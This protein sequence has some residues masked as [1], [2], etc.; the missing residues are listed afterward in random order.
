M[1]GKLNP[2]PELERLVQELNERRAG[3]VAD[4]APGTFEVEHDFAAELDEEDLRPLPPLSG[5]TQ[6]AVASGDPLEVLLGEAVRRGASDLL[7][8]PGSPPAVRIDGRLASLPA[9][10]VGAGAVEELLAPHLG[11][12]QRRALRDDGAVDFTLRLDGLSG[13]AGGEAGWRFRVNLH[14]QRGA[15]AA[16]LR[17]LPRRVPTLEELNLPPTLA[18]LVAPTRGLVLVCGPTGAGK[19]S[20]LAALV[21][22]LNRTRAAHVITIEDPIE[23]EHA[24]RQCL[25]EQVEVGTDAPSFAA[26]LRAGLRQDPDVILVGEMRDLETVATAL[27]AAET[28]HLILATLHTNDVVQAVH[29]IVDFFPGDQQSQIRQQL[30]L[31]LHAIVSQQLVP[32]RDRPGRVPAVEVLTATYA[33]RNHIRNQHLHRLYNEVTLGKRHGMVS[34]EDSLARLVRGGVVEVEEARIRSAHPE[35]LE[36][37]LRGGGGAGATT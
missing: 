17:A 3:A 32:R 2:D 24:S 31:A 12:R 37:L 20:T 1:S 4:A 8:V 10:P 16:A 36:S 26:A 30:A 21:G 25:V 7:L 13:A 11:A 27:T 23:Y 5:A 28:G 18:D 9:T 35:E 29:R 14:R 22:H 15:L 19:S 6:A 34:L 33:V